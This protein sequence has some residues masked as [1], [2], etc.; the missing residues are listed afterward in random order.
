VT[1]ATIC[2]SDIRAL[3]GDARR[4]AHGRII[5]GEGSGIIERVGDRVSR[6]G[7]GDR[8]LI[9]CLTSCGTC[10][11]CKRGRPAN[12]RKGGWLLGNAIDGTCADYVR[13][14]FADHSLIAT[15]G[16]GDRT[17]DGK[18]TSNLPDSFKPGVIHGPDEHVD[19]APIEFGGPVGMESVMAVMLYYRTVVRPALIKDRNRQPTPRRRD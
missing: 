16:A 12:C 6:F 7:V 9:S 5:G 2:G 19:A 10:A 8:V 18:W 15:G 17:T 13:A 1:G 14:P 3:R 11:S 4:I